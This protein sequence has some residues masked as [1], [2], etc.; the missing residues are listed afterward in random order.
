MGVKTWHIFGTL[1]VLMGLCSAVIADDFT[2]TS[3]SL[4]ATKTFLYQKFSG[5]QGETESSR[6]QLVPA[7]I[8]Y[9]V[10]DLSIEDIQEVEPHLYL[11]R[12]VDHNGN[13]I[14]AAW[15]VGVSQQKTL[16]EVVRV[17]LDNLSYS[18][19]TEE[20][21]ERWTHTRNLLL[22]AH[23][24]TKKGAIKME[25]ITCS[26]SQCIHRRPRSL[27]LPMEDLVVLKTHPSETKVR[28]RTLVSLRP[29]NPSN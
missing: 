1:G 22:G 15:S 2:S 24:Q 10:S 8:K 17:Y 20:D 27:N 9:L 13:L 26:E 21:R 23:Y 18:W 12:G 5:E 14:V 25:A 19:N 7:Q 6:I 3:R 11:G 16:E 28:V 29:E 4:K